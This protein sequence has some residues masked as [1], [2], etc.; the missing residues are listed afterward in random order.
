MGKLIFRAL[1]ITFITVIIPLSAHAKKT[2]NSPEIT[3]SP[4]YQLG[5]NAGERDGKKEIKL[6]WIANGLILGPVGYATALMAKTKLDE[7]SLRDHSQ[8]FIDGYKEGFAR[9]A[10][11]RRVLFTTLGFTV[12]A[13][14]TIAIVDIMTTQTFVIVE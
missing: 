11:K 12:N 1:V 5:F 14:V 6:R 7:D 4:D 13:Y 9:G 8:D 10:K 2:K 3:R